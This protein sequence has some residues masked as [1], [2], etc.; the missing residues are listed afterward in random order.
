MDRVL[1]DVPVVHAL[2]DAAHHGVVQLRE[3][4]QLALEALQAL[5][6]RGGAGG[7]ASFL[8]AAGRHSSPDCNVQP[9]IPRRIRACQ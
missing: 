6:Q 1:L 5:L 8:G 3:I 7:W 9:S 2:V 4:E